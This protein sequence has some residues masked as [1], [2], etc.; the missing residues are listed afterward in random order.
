MTCYAGPK[1]RI[2]ENLIYE[3]FFE[4]NEYY[5][6]IK[7]KKK[8]IKTL[9]TLIYSIYGRGKEFTILDNNLNSI[10]LSEIE[11]DENYL[12]KNNLEDLEIKVILSED[13]W[14][15]ELC[16]LRI[17]YIENEATH[18]YNKR[19]LAEYKFWD[20]NNNNNFF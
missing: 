15:D 16:F 5:I 4:N 12:N 1:K 20:N 18:D 9:R 14:L 6:L 11:L 17:R 7:T 10:L 8:N 13:D 3:F 19:L 2:L